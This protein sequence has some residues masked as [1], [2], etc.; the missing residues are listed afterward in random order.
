MTQPPNEFKIPR[1]AKLNREQWEELKRRGE[2]LLFKQRH[3]IE[4]TVE[5]PVLKFDPRPTAY[6]VGRT[7]KLKNMLIPLVNELAHESTHDS[8][9]RDM[10][11][12]TIDDEDD[13]DED[14]TP[15]MKRF[16]K[17]NKI[18]AKKARKEAK[19]LEK[20][21]HRIAER[22]AKEKELEE[23][24]KEQENKKLA[25]VEGKTEETVVLK[26]PPPPTTIKTDTKPANPIRSVE[27]KSPDHTII[28]M[29][30]ES[31]GETWNQQ[32]SKKHT[33][34]TVP[35]DGKFHAVLPKRFYKKDD[36]SDKKKGKK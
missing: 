13:F 8:N 34:P 22:E 15:A 9:W 14:W 30:S 21:Q 25:D 1:G 12:G 26:P 18:K 4:G 11:A 19:R 27:P 24:K 16:Y 29:P 36:K 28:Q 35:K 7:T 5:T 33:L 2:K 31:E 17:G 20:E 32:H 23:L 10:K 6:A 3:F